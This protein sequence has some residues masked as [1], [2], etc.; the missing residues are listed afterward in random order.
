MIGCRA[1]ETRTSPDCV[2]RRNKIKMCSRAKDSI[3]EIDMSN[4]ACDVNCSD[5]KTVVVYCLSRHVVD[6]RLAKI[7]VVCCR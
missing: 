3:S 1:G 5:K 7:I 6:C 2:N 4:V